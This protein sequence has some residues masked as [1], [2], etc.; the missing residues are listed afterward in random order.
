MPLLADGMLQL[1]ACPVVESV[2]PHVRP[3]PFLA[4]ITGIDLLV[5]IRL[6]VYL[7]QQWPFQ[8]HVEIVRLKSHVCAVT[9]IF[10]SLAI[11]FHS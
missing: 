2:R 10:M 4:T 5:T 11:S 8:D 3:I 1:L 7:T 6:E 9:H